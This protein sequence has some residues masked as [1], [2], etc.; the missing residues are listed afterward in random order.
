MEVDSNIA[1]VTVEVSPLHGDVDLF[2][3]RNDSIQFPDKNNNTA[4]S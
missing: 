2:V 3:S 4:R 1:N